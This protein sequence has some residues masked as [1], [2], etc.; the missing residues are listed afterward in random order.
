MWLAARAGGWCPG[1]GSRGMRW[2]AIAG[3]RV[4][5]MEHSEQGNERFDGGTVQATDTLDHRVEEAPPAFGVIARND[6]GVV[7]NI[8]R[9]RELGLETFVVD[10]PDS[11]P[12]IART[13]RNLDAEV[14][15]SPVDEATREELR[16]V[17]AAYARAKDV[18][19]LIIPGD[20]TK[21]IDVRASVDAFDPGEFVCDA[22]T[23]KETLSPTVMVAIPAYNEASTIREVV[24][25][26]M[27][28]AD[29]VVVVDDASEDNTASEA[30]AAGA[31][32][33]THDENKGY[34]GALNTAFSEA[35]ERDADQLVILDGDGQHDPSDIPQLLDTQQETESDIVIGSRFAPGSETDIPLYRRFGVEVVNTLT[36]F[37][38]G[39]VRPR[40][41]IRDTQSGFRAY[42]KRAI[43]SLNEDTSIGDGM[44]ASTDIL[45][46]GHQHSYDMQEVGARVRYDVDNASRHDPVSHGITL[47]SNLLKTIERDRPITSL[48][49]PGF[50]STLGGIGFA[51]WTFS[52]FLNTGTFPMGLAIT[53][54]FFGLAG[55]FACFTAIILHSLNRHLDE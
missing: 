36:N 55:I 29:H 4:T 38:M 33:V 8:T 31:E 42:N 6:L 1:T 32:V 28:H 52:N 15:Q 44:S 14:F 12:V 21:P 23:E 49:L 20:C 25:G 27:E 51:Y 30:Y 5:G 7:D 54:A 18:P 41:W 48:G 17:L 40:S 9:A 24:R 26:S 3:R 37:S 46:H 50:V 13:A 53:S 11:N 2:L 16:N 39:V 35:A 47:A 19:G 10:T 43:N 22:I 34:G 45:Y